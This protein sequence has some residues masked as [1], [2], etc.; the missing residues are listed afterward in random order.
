MAGHRLVQRFPFAAE[1]SLS[2]EFSLAGMCAD[3]DNQSLFFPKV[4]V[5]RMGNESFPRRDRH[6]GGHLGLPGI[7]H[8]N[9]WA[10]LN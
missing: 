6:S 10:C 9:R 8:Q 5:R 2:R 7:S 1:D 4:A 3:G